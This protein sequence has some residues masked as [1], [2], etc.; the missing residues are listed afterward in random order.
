MIGG[1]AAEL[2]VVPHDRRRYT[3]RTEALLGNNEQADTD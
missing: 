1:R 2:I 3:G